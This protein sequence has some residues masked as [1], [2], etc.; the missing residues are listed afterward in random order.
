RPFLKP[1][2]KGKPTRFN[3][4]FNKTK[5][6]DESNYVGQVLFTEMNEEDEEDGSIEFVLDN[7]SHVNICGNAE[8]F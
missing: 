7:A 2:L 1:I 4:N 8:A 6:E 3:P 5:H